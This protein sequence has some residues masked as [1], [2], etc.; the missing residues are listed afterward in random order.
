MAD[1]RDPAKSGSRRPWYLVLALLICSGLGA[2]GSTSG[3]G[4]IEIF[5]GAPFNNN[6]H[7][8]TREDDSK[9]VAAAGDRML[10]SMDEERPKAF[11]LAAGDLVLGVAMFILAAAAMTGRGG[12]RRVLVQLM[13]AQTAL[14][15]ATFLLTPKTRHAQ[16]DWVLTQDSAKSAESGQPRDQ[17]ER[18]RPALDVFYNGIGIG[19][20]A[21]RIVVAS[22]VI[23]ALTRR[24]SREFYETEHSANQG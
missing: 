8:Y 11:P 19:A 17:F 15:L 20:L 6:A 21:V 14:V 22:L 23:V 24:R 5:R 18:T 16:I 7:D 2:C 9:A 1:A 4:T 3:W 10:A 13:I 12:A